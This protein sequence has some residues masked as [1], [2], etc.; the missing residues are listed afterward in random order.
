MKRGLRHLRVVSETPFDRAEACLGFGELCARVLVECEQLL[1]GGVVHRRHC[2]EQVFDRI[3]HQSCV[4]CGRHRSRGFC[5]NLLEF[6]Q[7]CE[8]SGTIAMHTVEKGVALKHRLE[9]AVVFEQSLPQI[10][11]LGHRSD[12]AGVCAQVV[13]QTHCAVVVQLKVV[14]EFDQVD[15][16]APVHVL[17]GGMHRRQL[18]FA[19]QA[20]ARF[21][22][23]LL[24]FLV[25]LF[26]VPLDVGV[27]TV[28]VVVVVGA[29]HLALKP[30]GP[31]IFLRS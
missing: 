13:D 12:T 30:R 24:L 25:A 1:D 15:R 9:E 21:L 29:E 23:L 18:T 27:D 19:R 28:V 26:V 14:A 11:L 22:L 2:L 16:V 4:C 7:G 8:Y 3:G 17:K 31:S 6:L 5:Y 20:Q 10:S